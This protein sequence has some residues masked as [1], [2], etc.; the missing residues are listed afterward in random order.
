[1]VVIT[2]PKLKKEITK[3]LYKDEITIIIQEIQDKLFQ[4]IDTLDKLK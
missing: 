1:M 4:V 3:E 2:D